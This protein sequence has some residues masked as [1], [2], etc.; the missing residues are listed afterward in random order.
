MH[1]NC[2]ALTGCCLSD[3]FVLLADGVGASIVVYIT[4]FLYYVI[5]YQLDMHIF[6]GNI[7][8]NAYLYLLLAVCHCVIII[9][10]KVKEV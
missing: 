6:E 7:N 10:R 1:P 5:C 3:Q 4:I 9:G 2:I 8:S